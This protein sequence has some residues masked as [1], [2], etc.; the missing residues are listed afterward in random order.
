MNAFKPTAIKFIQGTE[1]PGREK[2]TAELEKADCDIPPP[3][4][5]DAIGKKTWKDLVAQYSDAGLIDKVDVIALEGLC[6]SYQRGRGYRQ[7]EQA[8]RNS[9]KRA[10]VDLEL[11]MV[12]GDAKTIE[13]AFKRVAYFEAQVDKAL[14]NQRREAALTR[15][16]LLEFGATP[17]SKNRLPEQVKQKKDAL[18]ELLDEQRKT[19]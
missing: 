6:M 16:Y 14:T 5:L 17:A 1:R 10:K 11:A 18:E 2:Q 9:L 3:R 4:S 12:G 7:D 15:Q 19:S 8:A 13:N